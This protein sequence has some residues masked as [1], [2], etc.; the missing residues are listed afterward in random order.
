[1]TT[2]P[3]ELTATTSSNACAC[4]LTEPAASG[5]KEAIDVRREVLLSEAEPL[6]GPPTENLKIRVFTIRAESSSSDGCKGLNESTEARAVDSADDG[7]FS[8]DNGMKDEM[9]DE[10]AERIR[11]TDRAV[12]CARAK[13]LRDGRSWVAAPVD[14][15]AASSP[16][17]EATPESDS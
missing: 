13:A 4:V 9:D 15:A 7:I 12:G 11:V 5:W 6:V 17:N 16:R 2:E 1:M 14:S 10:E 8:P 3:E